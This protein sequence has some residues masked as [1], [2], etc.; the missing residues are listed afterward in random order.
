MFN[1]PAAPEPNATAIIDKVALNKSICA[2][3]IIKPT[4]QVNTAKD[5]TLGFIKSNKA[6]G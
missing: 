1:A 2:G 4:T 6:L 5:I 3:A